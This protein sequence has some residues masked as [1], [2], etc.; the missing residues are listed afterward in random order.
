LKPAFSVPAAFTPAPFNEGTLVRAK[1]EQNVYLI[2]NGRKQLMRSPQEFVKLGL[3]WENV[4]E[5][6][7]DT[8]KAVTDLALIKTPGDNRV[9]MV[10]NGV[11]RWVRTAEVFQKSGYRWEDVKTVT[12]K[13]L[14]VYPATN[15]VRGSDGKVY[16]VSGNVRQWVATP[17]AFTRRGFKWAEVQKVSDQEI[18]AYRETAAL[19]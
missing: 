12:T 13:E 10:T 4:R 2:Q 6:A 18:T 15:L 14:A 16:T 8:V 19:K 5:V 17:Q 9:Y 11:R 1:G 3:K 7:A